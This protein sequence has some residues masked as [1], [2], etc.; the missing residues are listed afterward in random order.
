MTQPTDWEAE[1]EPLRHVV[2]LP[3]GGTASFALLGVCGRL[4]LRVCVFWLVDL[5]IQ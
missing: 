4:C 1:P 2:L 3:E 5:H